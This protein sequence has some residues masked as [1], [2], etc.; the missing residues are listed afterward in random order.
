M[1]HLFTKIH[2]ISTLNPPN[3]KLLNSIKSNE[4]NKNVQIE[5]ET[6]VKWN[7]TRRIKCEIDENDIA[8]G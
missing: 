6:K 8:I 2:L 5:T 3:R 4:M 1:I 7:Q